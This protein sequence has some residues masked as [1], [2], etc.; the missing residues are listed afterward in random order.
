MFRLAVLIL[1]V[2]VHVNS[3]TILNHSAS[4]VSRKI[5]QNED[6]N[7][8]TNF[9]K[10]D[11]CTTDICLEEATRMLS[12]L[13]ESVDP[14]ENVYDFACGKFLRDTVIPEDKSSQGAFLEVSDKVNEQ[15]QSALT[16]ELQ[17]NESKPFKLAKI[18]TKTCMNEAALNKKGDQIN[19]S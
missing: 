1:C 8:K 19:Y 13:D 12:F 16:E 14:C 6:E 3:A 7:T 9:K 18:F 4:K 17:P 15:L 2:T 11:I 10:A 5:Y